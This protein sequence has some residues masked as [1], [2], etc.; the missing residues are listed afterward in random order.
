LSDEQREVKAFCN[1]ISVSMATMSYTA[2]LSKLR[3]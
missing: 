3:A 1:S 2:L